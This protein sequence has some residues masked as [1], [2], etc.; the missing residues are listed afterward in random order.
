MKKQIALAFAVPVVGSL[1]LMAQVRDLRPTELST[2]TNVT[3]E[4]L[5]N[6]P[7]GDW[8]NWRRTDNNWGYSTLADI[9]KQNVNQMQLAWSWAMD[10]TGA[11]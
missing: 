4:M 9:N 3:E 5:R 10:D 7:A 11:N 1:A 6:P 8:L 2:Y